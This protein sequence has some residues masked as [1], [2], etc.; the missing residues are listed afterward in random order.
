MRRKI[1]LCVALVLGGFVGRCSILLLRAS[2]EVSDQL[3]GASADGEQDEQEIL[4]DL[5]NQFSVRLAAAS[6]PELT[7]RQNRPLLGS[8]GT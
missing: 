4:G 5:G 2:V 3:S 8:A 6:W 1:L 7:Q